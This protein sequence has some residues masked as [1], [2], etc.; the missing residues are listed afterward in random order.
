MFL[1][2]LSCAAILPA[3]PALAAE[4]DAARSFHIRQEKTSAHQ[5]LVS[6]PNP[7]DLTVADFLFQNNIRTLED[8]AA[9]L[10]SN[11]RFRG[12]DE[13]SDAWPS[14]QDVLRRKEGD[15][16]DYAV[17]TSAVAQVL[18]YQPQ[19]FA[20]ARTGAAHAVC[21]FKV[22][23]RYV[24]FDNAEMKTTKAETFVD[25]ARHITLNYQYNQLMEYDLATREW[26]PLYLRKA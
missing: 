8:Y 20:F 12:G 19:F 1:A 25:F 22:N 23:G 7:Q 15:C 5:V 17:L 10:K 4:N 2:G 18:G 21:A 16:E 9:W 24:W 26:T 11:V 14:P 13:F 6:R 3:T